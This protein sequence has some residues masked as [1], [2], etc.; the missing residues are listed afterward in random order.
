MRHIFCG[1]IKGK[2]AQGFHSASSATK[3]EK[4]ATPQL[5]EYF[6]NFNGY[7]KNVFIK[8]T[9]DG[10]Y[11]LKSSTL[12][13]KLLTPS[14][15]VPMFQNLYNNC[16]PAGKI[17]CFDNCYWK[18]NANYPFDIVIGLND[19]AKILSAYPAKRGTCKNHS[20][21]QDCGSEHCK[22]LLP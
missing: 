21:W 9:S 19:D 14:E 10:S 7:C 8:D 16:K 13:P 2:Y 17:L 22:D 12:W 11:E 4:C 15:L 3:Y 5:C 20:T 1:E 18:G 6:P